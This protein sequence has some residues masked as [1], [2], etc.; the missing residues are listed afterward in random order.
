MFS[1]KD[2]KHECSFYNALL[3]YRGYNFI[4]K[5]HADCHNRLTDYHRYFMRKGITFEYDRYYDKY[6]SPIRGFKIGNK[7]YK[8]NNEY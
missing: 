4:I 1:V 8:V 3:H 7:Y 2:I 5:Y 6:Y